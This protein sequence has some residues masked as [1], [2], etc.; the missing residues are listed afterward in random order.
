[1]CTSDPNPAALSD[2]Y[3]LFTAI[4]YLAI[5]VACFNAILDCI[6]NMIGRLLDLHI[7]ESTPCNHAGKCRGFLIFDLTFTSHFAFSY[8][9][10]L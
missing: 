2:V 1:M 9:Y 6:A 10:I 4:G 7:V 5:Y 3:R 8:I